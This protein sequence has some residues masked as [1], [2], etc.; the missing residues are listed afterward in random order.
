MT[1]T[2]DEQATIKRLVAKLNKKKAGNQT[3][4]RYYYQKNIVPF[5]GIKDPLKQRSLSFMLGWGTQAV[6]LI[7]E[8]IN[9]LNFYSEHNNAD[10]VKEV[11]NVF[12][13]NDFTNV[14][15]AIKRDAGVVGT[16]YSSVW[17]GDPEN[18]E[19]EIFI[20]A[21]SPLSTYGE[22]NL[23]SGLLDIAVQLNTFGEDLLVNLYTRN[24][25]ITAVRNKQGSWE[26]LERVQHGFNQVP[27]FQHVSN[28]DTMYPR[29]RTE[30]TPAL[31]TLIDDGIRAL[32]DASRIRTYHADPLFFLKGLETK[33]LTDSNGNIV[34]NLSQLADSIINL[35]YNSTDGYAPSV[36]Q[37]TGTDPNVSLEV[38][39]RLGKLAAREI[40][41]SPAQFG[42]STVNPSSAEAMNEADKGL[43]LKTQTRIP[44]YS[45][46]YKQMAKFV[47]KLK[48]I[49]VN[50]DEMAT[51]DTVF[52][53]PST[54]TPASFADYLSKMNAVGIFDKELPSFV[55]RG[56]EMSSVEILELKDWLANK[57]ET[58][59]PEN[60]IAL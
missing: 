56:M 16:T 30:I 3:N 26:E 7:S 48:N 15:Q 31:K 41:V 59:T 54:P 42:F 14:E 18:N 39:D 58:E 34:N 23:R 21:E 1:L 17:Y 49:E 36:E 29:G 28:A 46:T 44:Q 43:I 19:P 50:A 35:P 53:R 25:I 5:I 10:W 55:Y 37:I 57:P 27:I 2:N 47:L 33:N 9:F 38:V 60:D 13:L 40:G 52:R 4:Y 8:R 45:K 24:E 6:D 51:L 22:M 20:T 12:H 11:N 32:G